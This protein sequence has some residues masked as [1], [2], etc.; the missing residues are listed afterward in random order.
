[1]YISGVKPSKIQLFSGAICLLAACWPGNT[2]LA[3]QGYEI[4]TT[5]KPYTRGYVYLAHYFGKSIYVKD[6]VPLGPGGTAVFKGSEPLQGG[7]YM[8]V[9]PV[10]SQMVEMLVDSGSAHQHFGIEADSS[11]LVH[12]TRF[13]GSPDNQVF[14]AYQAYAADQFLKIKPLQTALASARTKADSTALVDQIQHLNKATSDYRA[15]LIR[16]HPTSFLA[17][18]FALMQEPSIPSTPKLANGRPDSLFAYRYYKTHYW[19]G[20][21]FSDERLLFTPIFEP[22]LNDYFGRL[23]SP[24]VDSIKEEVNHMI[25]YSRADKTMFKYFIT[26]FTNNYANPKY[27]GQDGVFLDLFE[28]Y[29]QTAQVDWLTDAQKRPIYDRAY[30]IMANQLGEPAADIQ[31]LDSSDRKVSL[32]GVQAPFTV[33][34]FWDPDCGHCQKEVPQLDSIYLAKWKSMGIKVF[35]VLI[36]TVKTDVGKIVPEKAHWLNY[37]NEHHLGDWV[38]VYQTP[39]MKQE[40]IDA[41]KAGFRQLYDVYQTPTIYLLDDQKKIIGKKLSVEQVDE[42]IQRRLHKTSSTN[43]V[44][45]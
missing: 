17:T 33:I 18:L 19:D 6:S 9:N 1:M 38:N 40:D 25:L 21:S 43:P 13:T 35:A 23:V 39:A 31:L 10:K 45:R 20:V 2:L 36:D 15:G 37:I 14:A 42:L 29:Y 26:T 7:I 3:Q 44:T 11:D 8:L 32:Y 22:K 34:C 12:G 30:S 4:R 41:K 28:K 16:Q 24:E 5:F 27:M